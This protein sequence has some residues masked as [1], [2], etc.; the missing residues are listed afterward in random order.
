MSIS[1]RFASPLRYP[2]GKGNLTPFIEKII[3]KNNLNGCT[4]IEP[5]AGGA[6]IAIKL[7][8]TEQVSNIVIN[9]LDRSI[10]A[11]WHAVLNHNEELIEKINDVQVTIDE[12]Q[13]QKEI[14]RKKSS[15][16]LF[17]LAFS[18]F[19]LNRTNR[20]GIL[21]AWPIGG[22]NQNGAWKIDAR[23]YR[24][25][26][27]ERIRKIGEW[28]DSIRI[29]NEDAANLMNNV[30]TE[31]ETSK[32]LVYLDPPYYHKGPDLYFDHYDPDDHA[33]LARTIKKMEHHWIVSYDDVPEIRRLYKCYQTREWDF[34]YSARQNDR[35][36]REVLFFNKSLNV[37]DLMETVD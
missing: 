5:Y 9:D 7:L 21:N 34:R 31:Y 16:E 27:C 14:Q 30:I 6:A 12:W 15:A 23:F 26:L 3:Q 29:C 36:A 17:D 2:G 24:P 19:F 35:Y 33:T 13:N 25:Q 37:P 28:A 4:Y 8:L 18:T 1:M 22:I 20:S 11:F 32:T 10:F